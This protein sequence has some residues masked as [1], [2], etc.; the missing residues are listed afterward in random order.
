MARSFVV[1]GA[2]AV[3]LSLGLALTVPTPA[4]APIMYYADGAFHCPSG[5]IIPSDAAGKWPSSELNGSDLER[6]VAERDRDVAGRKLCANAWEHQQRLAGKFG[7]WVA[8]D[9]AWRDGR[10]DVYLSILGKWT[11]RLL[12]AFVVLALL[13]RRKR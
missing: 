3:F 9:T 2:P 5:P 7:D 10:S 13:F 1:S 4:G 11:G 12:V 8:V 6:A